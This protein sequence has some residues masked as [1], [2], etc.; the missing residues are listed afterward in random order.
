M[1]SYLVTGAGRGLGLAFTAELLK[2]KDNT[3]IATARNVAGSSGLRELRAQNGEGRLILLDLDVSNPESIRSTAEETTKLLPDGL[4]NLVSSAGV[5]L[6]PLATFDELD[7]EQ[8]ASE[9]NF[10]VTASFLVVRAFLPL[11]RRSKSK[12]I[13][14]IS[15]NVGSLELAP[16]MPNVGNAYG[17]SRAA[18]NMLARKWSPVLKPDGVIIALVHPGWVGATDMGSTLVDFVARY[19]IPLE[20]VPAET[21]AAGCMKVLNDLTIDDSGLFFNFDGTRIPF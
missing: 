18:L 12:K 9:L 20:N 21:S 2:N 7:A 1:P 3:V 10:T 17:I 13:F 5:N 8:L 4:D 15:S 11:I 6:N 19:E 16:T 14:I